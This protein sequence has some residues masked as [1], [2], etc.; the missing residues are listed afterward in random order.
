MHQTRYACL[1][2]FI[3]FMPKPKL[4]DSG[5]KSWRRRFYF[6][7][8]HHVF[9]R[10]RAFPSA[11]ILQRDDP[12]GCTLIPA[13]LGSLHEVVAGFGRTV[14]CTGEGQRFLEFPSLVRA[15]QVQ[16]P[17]LREPAG[18]KMS[19]MK[20]GRNDMMPTNEYVEVR[21]GGYYVADT[22]IGLDVVVYDFRRGRSAEAIFEAYPSI[23]SLAKVYGAITFI[24]KHP[25]AVEAYLKDQDRIMEDL[26][27]QYPMPPDMIDRFERAKKE[28]PRRLA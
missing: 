28:E 18:L 7:P 12:L 10:L 5:W 2:R 22:R 1:S 15:G 3:S 27:A 21:N 4:G 13:V 9:K 16:R 24:L 8:G 6:V 23:G 19:K 26:K 17:D 25:D 11:L 20:V 14:S